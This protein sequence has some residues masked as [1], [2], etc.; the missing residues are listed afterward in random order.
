MKYK[1]PRPIIPEAISK[2]ILREMKRQKIKVSKASKADLKELA[3]ICRAIEKTGLPSYLVCKKLSADL[4]HGIFLNPQAKTIL[5]GEVIGSYAGQVTII[6]QNVPDDAAYAFAPVSD[7]HLDAQEQKIYDAKR[8]YH[9]NRLYS[10]MLDAFKKGNFTRF[11]NHS[12]KPNVAA[13]L[14]SIPKNDFDLKPSPIEVIYIAL[15][16]ILPG[17]QLLIS[18]EDGEKSYW[19]VAKIKPFPMTPKTFI[20]DEKLKLIKKMEPS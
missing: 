6:P 8:R 14:L 10:L 15:K 9:P 20:L 19:G 4:G 13:Y 2:I 11:I 12:E 18:Y 3:A 7:M 16:K 5:K 17:E 1:L